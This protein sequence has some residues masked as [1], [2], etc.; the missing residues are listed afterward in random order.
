M[1]ESTTPKCCSGVAIRSPTDVRTRSWRNQLAIR[2]Q[3]RPVRF[4]LPPWL[5]PRLRIDTV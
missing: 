4:P 3:L 1:S 2:F 5:P